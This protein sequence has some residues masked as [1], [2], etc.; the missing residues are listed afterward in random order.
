MA[1]IDQ[2]A[3]A[4]QRPAS[5]PS[6]LETGRNCWRVERADRA[7]VLVDAEPYFARL[8]DAMRRARR[9]IMIIGWDFDASIALRGH[10]GPGEAE[11]LGEML[12][13]LVEA[14]PELEVRILIWNLSTLH[15][16]SAMAPMILGDKW[17]D[18]PRI[19]LRLDHDHPVYAAQHQKVVVIDD[20]LAF[21]GGMDLTV[22]RWDTPEHRMDDERRVNA[23][24]KPYEPVHDVHM[25]VDG[26]AARAVAEMARDRWTFAIGET[27][28]PSAPLGPVP[29][30]EG[31]E[32]DFRGVPVG[33]ARTA[34][35]WRGEP[36]VREIALLTL[37]ALRSAGSHVYIEAQ[38]LADFRVGDCLAELLERPDG[39]EIVIV[40]TRFRDAFMEKK[41][42][43]ENRDR[44]IRRL[45]R[46]DR[47]GRLR[48]YCLAVPGQGGACGVFVHSKVMVIDDRILRVGSANLNNRS[49]GLDSE[50]DL[51]IEAADD[52]TAAQVAAVRTR[53]LA[54]HLGASEE[55]VR[56][57]EFETGSLISAIEQLNGGERHLNRI[58][59]DAEGPVRPAFGTALV[60]PR[61]P[62]PFLSLG[63][64]WWR[65]VTGF[66][67]R[68]RSW[69]GETNEVPVR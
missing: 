20:C 28:A 17:C 16:P 65:R 68:V 29:W 36:A 46:A 37:D 30:P 56:Q 41:F 9:S 57:A 33:I 66:R 55:A 13:S 26:A 61:R 54:E 11:R 8:D 18:H 38:Y 27:L 43:G 4:G 21:V 64:R 58:T 22:S 10:G 53:L 12:R 45:M 67:P 15:A 35:R 60:D 2:T 5:I 19:Q 1:T 49:T 39:P 3:Q 52:Q 51:V 34:P 62:I 59:A 44:L 42:M 69:A 31:L 32:P 6:V 63:R 7:S 25:V 47:H 24:G 23:D 48:T 40:V 50:C 14:N